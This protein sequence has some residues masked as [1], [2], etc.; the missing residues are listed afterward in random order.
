M[1]SESDPGISNLKP[2]TLIL[3][4]PCLAVT[5]K[6]DPK[7]SNPKPTGSRGALF[8]QGEHDSDQNGR[9]RC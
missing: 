1:T 8:L 9:Q 4:D 7:H 6:S 5:G 2:E 3:E